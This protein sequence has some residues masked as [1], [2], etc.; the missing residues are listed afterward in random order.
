MK[1]ITA[2]LAVLGTLGLSASPALAASSWSKPLA[3][4]T[5]VHR[6]FE[7]PY[8]FGIPIFLG[9]WSRPFV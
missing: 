4:R 6:V 1:R 7:G 2:I 9:T 5:A 8:R 3:H